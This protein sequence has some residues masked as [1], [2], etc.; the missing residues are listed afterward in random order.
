MFVPDNVGGEETTQIQQII[1]Y[2]TPL[3]KTNIE[4]LKNNTQE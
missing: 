4:N 2:G 1:F 3:E